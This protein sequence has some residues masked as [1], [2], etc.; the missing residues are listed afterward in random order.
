MDIPLLEKDLCTQSAYKQNKKKKNRPYMEKPHK[1]YDIVSMISETSSDMRHNI[2]TT[3]DYVV[4]HGECILHRTVV[5]CVIKWI[6]LVLGTST[7]N[8]LKSPPK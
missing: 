2:H 6:Y 7:L 3:L 1:I 5:E 8:V 4:Q